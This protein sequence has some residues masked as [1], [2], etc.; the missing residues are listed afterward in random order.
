M[1][2]IK[3]KV[4]GLTRLGFKPVRSKSSDL[5]KWETDA[6]LIRSFCLVITK[7][8]S[9]ALCHHCCQLSRNSQSDGNE[10][11]DQASPEPRINPQIPWISLLLYKI[12]RISLILHDF[13]SFCLNTSNNNIKHNLRYQPISPWKCP[14]IACLEF[15][16]WYYISAMYV[17][18]LL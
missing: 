17:F 9:M 3:F 16:V 8:T 5:P 2:S 6:L 7:A 4:I 15:N 1:T 18:T 12:P 13:L 10:G 11:S 14:Q